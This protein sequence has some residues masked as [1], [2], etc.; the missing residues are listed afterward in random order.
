MVLVGGWDGFGR[1]YGN[2]FS[3]LF[4]PA[5]HSSLA[6]YRARRLFGLGFNVYGWLGGRVCGVG[7]YRT[8]FTRD[9]TQQIRKYH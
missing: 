5:Q 3:Y 9:I 7:I 1:I 2:T 8:F 4:I 6:I